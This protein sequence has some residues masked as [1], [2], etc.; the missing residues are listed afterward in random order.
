[1]AEATKV[2]KIQ[3]ITPD[4]VF[5]NGTGSMIEFN[6]TEGEMGCYPMHVPTT[7][8]LAPGIV[9]IHDAVING[10]EEIP[11]KPKDDGTIIAAVH[12][13]FAEILADRVTI[14]AEIAE[15]PSEIDASRA[16]AAQKRAEDRISGKQ[17]ETDLVRAELALRRSLVRQKIRSL[18]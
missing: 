14:L 3:I 12:A 4:R 15:W 16:A 6:T 5:Y 11:E 2:F 18:G 9:T 1:M 8:V 13:G 10:D 17:E 7:V